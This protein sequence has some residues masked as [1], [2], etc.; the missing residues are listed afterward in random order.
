MFQIHTRFQFTLFLQGF[1]LEPQEQ[2]SLQ[3]TPADLQGHFPF[4]WQVDL[5]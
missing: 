4:R 1:L 5:Q 3:C 2:D